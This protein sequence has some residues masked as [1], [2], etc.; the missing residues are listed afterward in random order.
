MATIE[1]YP[2]NGFWREFALTPVETETLR[3]A[4]QQNF[5]RR[6]DDCGL[7]HLGLTFDTYHRAVEDATHG[8]LWPRHERRLTGETL[9]FIRNTALMRRLEDRFG[10]LEIT[11]EEGESEPEVTWRLVR[12][13]K[14]QDVGPLHADAWF[15]DL[16]GWPIPE[17]KVCVK[18]WSLLHGDA[19]QCGLYVVPGSHRG[20][21]AAYETVEK[22][23]IRKPVLVEESLAHA[24]RLLDMS[25][26][27]SVVFDYGLL[28]GGS[29]TASARA[30]VSFE[31]TVFADARRYAEIRDGAPVHT[32]A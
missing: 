27:E 8:Q 2:Q 23:G 5:A 12:P 32:G 29:V 4:V 20:G 1:S 18:I 7:G 3:S 13:G 26:G 21:G 25:E 31:F 30:R 9:A 17:G 24:P 6:L 19:G 15:W 28:H 10:A 16:N 14:A 22:D 11:N